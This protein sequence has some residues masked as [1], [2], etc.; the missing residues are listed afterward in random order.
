MFSDVELL[1]VFPFL[2]VHR[3]FV[4]AIFTLEKL[5]K[6][7]HGCSLVFIHSADC[8]LFGVPYYSLFNLAFGTSDLAFGFS[9]F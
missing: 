4:I 9:C 1:S 3:I 8:F 5:C 2:V 6:F 7:L